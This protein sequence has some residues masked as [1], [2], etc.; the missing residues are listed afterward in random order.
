MELSGALFLATATSDESFDT[1]AVLEVMVLVNGLLSDKSQRVDL[2][3]FAAT[4]VVVQGGRV[5]VTSGT[6][7]EVAGGLSAFKRESLEPLFFDEFLDARAVDQHGGEVVAMRGTPG[8]LR[9]YKTKSGELDRS[10]AS[11][12]ANVA[13]SKATVDIARGLVFYAAGDEGLRVVHLRRGTIVA[14]LP[15]PKIDGVDPADA[16]TNAVSVHGNLVF[17]ANGGAGLFVAR[18]DRDLDSAG[19]DLN[20]LSLELI[21]RVETASGESVNYVGGRGNLL[22]VAT[23][24]GG[25]EIM[26]IVRGGGSF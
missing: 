18:A 2:P 1:P 17:L 26:R 12:G 10:F 11:G 8:E 13:E 23:G 6:G 3:S 4:G 25:L 15:V 24:T 7:G 16:V 22:F 9:I 19:G 21:G 20:E 14:E 5:F